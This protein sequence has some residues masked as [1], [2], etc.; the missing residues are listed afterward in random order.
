MFY[1]GFI[2]DI[3]SNPYIF[4]SKLYSLSCYQ[5]LSVSFILITKN[6]NQVKV[7]A[8]MLPDERADRNFLKGEL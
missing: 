3:P 5:K 4:L 7:N 2:W 8:F 1:L 6:E